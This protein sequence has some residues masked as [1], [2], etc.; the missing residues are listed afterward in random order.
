M[1]IV[2]VDESARD[3]DYYFFGALIVDGDAARQIERGMNEVAALIASHVP[4]FSADTEFHA[5]NMFH[6]TEEWRNVPV[7][8]RVKACDLTAK[9]IGR[10]TAQFVFRGIDLN[11]QRAKYKRPFPPHLLALAHS[12]EE[13][14]KRLRRMVAPE[15][16]GLVVADEHHSATSAR[17]SLRDFRIGKVPGYTTRQL[18]AVLDTIYFGPSHESRLLQAADVATYFLNRHRT[19]TEQDD[20]ARSAVEKIVGNIRRVTVSEYV[21]SPESP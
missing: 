12:L 16:C 21:W 15:N 18:D 19:I 6:G 13:V 7:A 3:N 10:S 11:A 9:I 5:V 4:G 17:R 14:D 20:R 1:R 2:Y 8:W